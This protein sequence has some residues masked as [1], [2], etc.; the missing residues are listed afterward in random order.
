M[1]CVDA[2]AALACSRGARGRDVSS[3]RGAARCA[4]FTSVNATV[5]LRQAP[6]PAVS[7]YLVAPAA[8]A[9]SRPNVLPARWRAQTAMHFGRSRA[10]VRPPRATKL[11]EQGLRPLGSVAARAPARSRRALHAKR[12]FFAPP[13]LR[14]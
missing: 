6:P 8:A 13:E 10:A 4:S 12:S 9:Q 14:G 2:A 11:G 7:L 5:F 3:V 1:S